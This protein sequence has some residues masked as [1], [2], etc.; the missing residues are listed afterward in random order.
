[1]TMNFEELISRGTLGWSRARVE[2]ATATSIAEER[3]STD[4]M[5]T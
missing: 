4:E 1:L 3:A 5:R 2:D